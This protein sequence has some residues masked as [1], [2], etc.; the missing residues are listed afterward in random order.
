M[1]WPVTH[2][3]KS[4]AVAYLLLV[5]LPIV[6]LAGVLRT[7]RTLAAPISIGGAWKMHVQAESLAGL[8]CGGSLPTL[9]AEGFTISQSGKD[10][11]L[12]FSNPVMSSASGTIDGTRIKVNLS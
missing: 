2:A 5:I 4:F 6:G 7:G 1:E 10:F 12:N 3:H 11:T 8:P 9:R